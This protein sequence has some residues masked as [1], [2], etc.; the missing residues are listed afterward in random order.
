MVNPRMVI[1]GYAGSGKTLL[2]QELAKRL[3][4]QG[5]KVLLL[6]FN[7]MV[8][9]T[10][11]YGIEKDSGIQCTTFH[12]LARE[13]ITAAEPD[14]W[15]SQNTKED[16][17]W[18]LT[19]PLKLFELDANQIEK[20]DAIIVDEGQDLKRE[21]Y[22]FLESLLADKDSGNF[23]VFYDENQDI[24]GRWDDLPWGATDVPRKVLR[25]NCRNTKLIVDYINKK[26]SCEMESA[27]NVPRGQQVI[28]R[29]CSS[30]ED[31]RKK[32]IT[33][34]SRLL[35]D[36]VEPGQIVILLNSSKADSCLADLS[37][38]GSTA[39]EAMGHRYRKNSRAIQYSTIRMFKGLE[40]EVV[41]LVGLD[42]LPEENL[43]EAI[44]TQGSRAQSLLYVYRKKVGNKS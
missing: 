30:V 44:Y 37:E 26:Y 22:E 10:V 25:K 8:A 36:G 27:D 35:A 34:I 3:D 11:R 18:N 23:V 9:N 13:L 28:E 32:L 40:A 24:F 15:D 16:D 14:W 4:A 42:N 20:Y 5:K 43:A 21:W 33:D 1:K 6:F 38:V 41:F 29:K 31:E 19:V 12:S 7:R 39:V 17:F 2:A